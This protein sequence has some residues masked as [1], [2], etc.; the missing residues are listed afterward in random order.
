MKK[1]LFLPSNFLRPIIVALPQAALLVGAI[2]MNDTVDTLMRLYPLMAACVLGIIFTFVYFFKAVVLSKDEIKYIGPFSSRDSAVINEGKTLILTKKPKGKLAIDLFGN[3]GVNASLDWLK[4]E[5]TV[6]DVY[7]FKG[8]VLGGAL[9][10]RSV[11][12]FF[13]VSV[14]DAVALLGNSELTLD[15]PDYTLT[16]RDS[17]G[18][19]EIRIKFKKTL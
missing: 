19:R 9:A 1:S 4:S 12:K 6:R 7:L 14:T 18:E 17:D 2:L 10:A 13:G 8:K 11:L 15:Y 3:D 16:S 5:T